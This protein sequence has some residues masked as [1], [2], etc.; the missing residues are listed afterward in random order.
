M[1]PPRGQKLS[2]KDNS[3]PKLRRSPRLT[4]R[5][6]PGKALRSAERLAPGGPPNVPLVRVVP[7]SRPKE[8]VLQKAISGRHR[9]SRV[10][11]WTQE[12]SGRHGR[13]S[14]A[15]HV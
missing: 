11:S 4:Y 1:A 2:R 13:M 3:L 5:A 7:A 9:G 6:A 12:I 10:A 14:P 15:I 8:S